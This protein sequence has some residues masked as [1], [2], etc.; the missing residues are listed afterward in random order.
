MASLH[1]WSVR[2]RQLWITEK[3][4]SGQAEDIISFKGMRVQDP[5]EAIIA[6]KTRGASEAG[7]GSRY[8]IL[9]STQVARSPTD[10]EIRTQ[11][12]SCSAHL[13][14]TNTINNEYRKR[15]RKPVLGFHRTSQMSLVGKH[16]HGFWCFAV[17]IEKWCPLCVCRICSFR[18]CLLMWE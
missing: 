14:D 4:T 13:A 10:Q 7:V 15:Q 12:G 17:A 2:H 16:L 5:T 6:K 11:P 9:L 1:L 3:N 8:N 18:L